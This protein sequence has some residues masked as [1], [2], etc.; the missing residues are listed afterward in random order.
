MKI[1][2]RK[3]A[4][5]DLKKI[6]NPFK[7]NIHNKILELKNFPDITNI[8]KLTNFE[9]AYRVRVGEYR[10]LFDVFDEVI[11]IARVLHRKESYK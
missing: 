8:K 10:I 2:I 1:E 9:P 7:S 3:S 5:K 11:Y 6:S 4:I